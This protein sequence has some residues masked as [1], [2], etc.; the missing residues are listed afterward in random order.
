LVSIFSFSSSIDQNKQ[1]QQNYLSADR[2]PNWFL[3]SPF[4]LLESATLTFF[5]F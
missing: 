4:V 3:R 5:S 1:Q 2:N